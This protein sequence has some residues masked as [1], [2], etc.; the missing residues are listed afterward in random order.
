MPYVCEPK[1]S[2]GS[3]GNE[4]KTNTVKYIYIYI[5]IYHCVAGL[6]HEVNS[7]LMVPPVQQA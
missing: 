1:Q 2:M 4:R 3:L 6:Q 5:Y 7:S